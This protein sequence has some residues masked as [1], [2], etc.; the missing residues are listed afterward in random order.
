MRYLFLLS[1]LLLTEQQAVL[2]TLLP[3][4]QT[5]PTQPTYQQN[6]AIGYSNSSCVRI[7][8]FRFQSAASGQASALTLNFV[9]EAQPTTGTLYISLYTGTAVS[10]PN[11]VGA[12]LNVQFNTDVNQTTYSLTNANWT[13]MRG[14]SYFLTFN[15]QE[16]LLMPYYTSSAGSTYSLTLQQ[17]PQC[18]STQW[19]PLMNYGSVLPMLININP[20][21]PVS[22]INNMTNTPTN[23]VSDSSTHTNAPTNPS[24]ITGTATIPHTNSPISTDML[25]P[26]NSPMNSPINSPRVIPESTQEAT[27]ITTY[28]SSKSHIYASVSASVSSLAQ[29][30]THTNT[31]SFSQT[32]S[33]SPPPS[34][35]LNVIQG[36][37]TTTSYNPA[38]IAGY[39]L[40]AVGLAVLIACILNNVSKKRETPLISSLVVPNPAL[41]VQPS[42]YFSNPVV[43]QNEPAIP[44]NQWYRVVEDGDTYYYNDALKKSEWALPEGGVIIGTGLPNTR[45]G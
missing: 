39:T 6:Y 14:S 11:R 19:T 21:N 12:P 26:S 27:S 4:Q 34:Q 37:G 5:Q 23:K 43:T 29:E 7:S 45:L 15:T 16:R 8:M 24:T 40:G 17:A 9:S 13:F 20:A 28:T 32:S 3:T 22:G 10:G 2:N 38:T 33:L 42:P 41:V 30:N 35:P 18:N 31:P 36:Q 44:T 1:T 25:N